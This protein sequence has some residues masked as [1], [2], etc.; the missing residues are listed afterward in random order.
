MR[1]LYRDRVMQSLTHTTWNTRIALTDSKRFQACTLLY[2]HST[3]EN[4]SCMFARH[5]T[6]DDHNAQDKLCHRSISASLDCKMNHHKGNDRRG[7][8]VV[9]HRDLGASPDHTPAAANSKFQQLWK[10]DTWE[11]KVLYA[12]KAK[13]SRLSVTG[14]AQAL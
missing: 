9:C 7:P 2:L 14:N 6:G 11:D 10:R 3:T 4:N 1:K 13:G 12:I 8:A 5:S